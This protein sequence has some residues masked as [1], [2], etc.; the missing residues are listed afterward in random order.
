M[1]GPGRPARLPR[2]A[3]G[4]RI[5]LFGGSFN[6]PHEG[7]RLASLVALRR[8][9]LDAIWW[10]VTPG[11]P[12]KQNS[13]LPEISERLAAARRVAAHPRIIV[14]DLEAEIGTRYTIDTL[15]YLTRRCAGVDFV[16][17]MGADNL[18]AFH[19]WRRWRDIAALAP[20]VVIDRPGSTLKGMH[21]RA[22]Q[23]FHRH[24]YD[25]SD[26]ALLARAKAPAFAFLHGPRSEASSTGL[27]NA[28]TPA[29]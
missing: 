15:D 6:P 18:A 28:A 7:H 5:G 1:P 29:R 25:E 9:G 20:V 12:L 2:H 13:G 14:T 11:N 24:R 16:W 27:R 22:G 4:M 3:P 26:A 23:W 19:R 17:I 8:L 21:T 10:L